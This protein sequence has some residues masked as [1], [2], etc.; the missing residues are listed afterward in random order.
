MQKFFLLAL[1]SAA[2]QAAAAPLACLIEPDKVAEIG[3]PRIGIIDKV[4]VE[5]GDMVKDGQVLATLR[6]DVERAAVGVARTRAQADA[7]LQAAKA[8]HELAKAKL[9]RSQHLVDVGFISKEALDQARAEE[10]IAAQRV[11]QV[12]EAQ[13]TSKQELALSN[14]QLAQHVI[15]SPFSGIVVDRFRTEG[16]RVEREAV[17]RVAKIDPLRVEVV[18]P[19]SEYG[20]VKRG[21]SM[22]IRT[23]IT[24][25]RALSA[26]VMLVDRVLDAASDTFRVRLSL[27][28]PDHSIP[29]GLRCM[30]ELGAPAAPAQVP[31][32]AT[33]VNG[34]VLTRTS[35]RAEAIP[36][37]A[38]VPGRMKLSYQLQNVP[39]N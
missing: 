18:L 37:P 32:A 13:Q 39:K 30:A 14:S 24:G 9:A 16:E 6:A 25:E 10:K 1:M 15:R 23:D 29:A 7:D 35:L 11:L 20:K 31:A 36:A 12:Q 34:A 21:D 27:P 33:N 22:N 8:N 2:T 4:S 28:N 38:P 26:K 3:A 19:S 17:V 5:R